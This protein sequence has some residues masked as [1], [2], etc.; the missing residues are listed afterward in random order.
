MIHALYHLVTSREIIPYALLF[1]AGAA[2]VWI[3]VDA[4]A[5]AAQRKQ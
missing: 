3:A 1:A 4:V 5:G 2:A